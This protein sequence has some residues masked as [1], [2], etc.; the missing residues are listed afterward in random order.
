MGV[1]AWCFMYDYEG[2]S[3]FPFDEEFVLPD[4]YSMG[5]IKQ[6]VKNWQGSPYGTDY[7]MEVVSER[8]IIL[9]KAKHDM[10]ICCIG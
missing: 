3:Q 8:H 9:T 1:P 10:K 4:N 7:V 2:P 5:D 6:R